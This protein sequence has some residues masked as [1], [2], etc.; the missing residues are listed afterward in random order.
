[1][2]SAVVWMLS[3]LKSP[4]PQSLVTRWVKLADDR[5]FAGGPR[6]SYL[7]HGIAEGLSLSLPPF[8]FTAVKFGGLCIFYMP[9]SKSN[10]FS[11][12]EASMTGSSETVIQSETSFLCKL[13]ISGISYSDRNVSNVFIFALCSISIK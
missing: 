3:A 1:M 10:D 2:Q 8:C 12:A 13:I 7:D 5:V 6:S 4:C 11:K 9:L